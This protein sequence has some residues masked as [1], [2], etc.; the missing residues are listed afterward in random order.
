MKYGKV[1]DS[2]LAYYGN[3]DLGYWQGR[4]EYNDKDE[5]LT[6]AQM[7]AKHNLK[8]KLK[9]IITPSDFNGRY[10]DYNFAETETEIKLLDMTD[11]AKKE[12][13]KKQIEA[14]IISLKKQLAETDYVTIKY[15][16]AKSGARAFNNGEEEKC[17]DV[18]AERETTREKIR[19]LELQL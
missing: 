9:P 12:N 19:L 7:I 18:I 15:S 16:E 4:I 6:A 1:I 5:R 8:P 17:L 2:K 14:E 13:K 11:T 3:D 10:G